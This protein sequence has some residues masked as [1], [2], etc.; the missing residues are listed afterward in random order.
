M[1]DILYVCPMCGSASVEFS[2][3]VGGA[4]ECKACSW[5]GMRD[6]LFGVPVALDVASAEVFM[7]MRNDLRRLHAES[8]KQYVRFLVKWGLVDAVRDERQIRITD[9][10]QVV[11]YMNA[12]A[13]ATF[14][15]VLEEHQQMEKERVR[16]K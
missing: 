14:K 1:K 5:K 3:L 12:I 4:A 15:A 7:S 16:G 11:R 9:K 10:T 13:S 6:D 8:A 2:E